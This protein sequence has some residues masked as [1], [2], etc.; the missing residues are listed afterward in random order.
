MSNSRNDRYEYRDPRYY[1]EQR[2]PSR[3]QEEYAQRM[4]DEMWMDGDVNVHTDKHGHQ[5]FSRK[6]TPSVTSSVTPVPIVPVKSKEEIKEQEDQTRKERVDK[7]I[8]EDD[9]R[10][11]ENYR[12]NNTRIPYTDRPRSWHDG[13]D[14]LEGTGKTYRSGPTSQRML[15]LDPNNY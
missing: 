7:L 3:Y 5:T 12:L 10:I 2:R 4:T 1:N 14:L 9:A 8:R 6:P 13:T 15:E 11:Q